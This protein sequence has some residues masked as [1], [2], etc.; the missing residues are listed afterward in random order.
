MD[1]RGI[2]AVDDILSPRNHTI[3]PRQIRQPSGQGAGSAMSDSAGEV[4]ESLS[5]G[6]CG[7]DTL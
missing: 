2:P 5:S 6:R 1:S 3:R 4:R 7:N